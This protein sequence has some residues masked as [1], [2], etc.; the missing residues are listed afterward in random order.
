MGRGVPSPTMG[1]GER[2]KLPQRGPKMDFMHILGQ[3]EAI[4]NTIF[5][6]F[7]RRRPPPNVAGSGKTFSL[8]LPSRRAWIG[9]PFNGETEM[10][11]FSVL[12]TVTVTV[13]VNNTA[14]SGGHSARS[15]LSQRD[16]IHLYRSY[17]VELC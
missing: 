4:W 16:S 6:I 10:N 3:K 8:P 13:N 1:S 9:L 12:V 11:I 7:E 2:R 17:L 15:R 5:S 14:V